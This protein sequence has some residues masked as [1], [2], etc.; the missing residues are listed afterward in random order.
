MKL[1]DARLCVDCDEVYEATRL[2]SVCPACASKAFT[3]VSR[4]VPTLA[5][6]EK[7]VD[8]Q[9]QRWHG[10]ATAPRVSELKEEILW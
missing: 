2:Y 9:K 5:E 6:F 4:F 3:L 8:D 1:R 7:F 10:D